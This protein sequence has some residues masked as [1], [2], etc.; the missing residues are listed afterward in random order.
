[1]KSQPTQADKATISTLNSLLRGE[2]SA[3]E[4]YNQAIKQLA[5]EPIRDL[6]ENRDDHA[7]RIG[8]LTQQVATLGGNPETSSGAWGS[9]AKLV[10]KSASLAGRKA[11]LAALEEGEDRGLTDYRKASD[12]IDHVASRRVIDTELLPAQKRTHARMSQ[13]Q[14]VS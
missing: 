11:I 7:R 3:V 12:S 14:Q 2:L 4:T 9:V 6:V 1:M 5:Q 10:E 13:L 8:I